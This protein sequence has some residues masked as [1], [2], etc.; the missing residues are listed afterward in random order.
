MNTCSAVAF[1]TVVITGCAVQE[2]RYPG[3]GCPAPAFRLNDIQIDARADRALLSGTYPNCGGRV[4]LLDLKSGAE[5]EFFGHHNTVGTAVANRDFTLVL[6]SGDYWATRPEL[7]LWDVHRPTEPQ[8][9]AG[10]DFA[11]ECAAFSPDGT[12]FAAAGGI[13]GSPFLPGQ[14]VLW[15]LHSRTIK[16]RIPHPCGMVLAIAFSPDGSALASASVDGSVSIWSTRDGQPMRS[17]SQQGVSANSVVFSPDGRMLAAAGGSWDKPGWLE[18]WRLSDYKQVVSAS[19][20]E[21]IYA[22]AWMPDGTRLFA[23]GG[24]NA[25]LQ[26]F[27]LQEGRWESPLLVNNQYGIGMHSISISQY[28]TR[29]LLGMENPTPLRWNWDTEKAVFERGMK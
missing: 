3:G 1:A 26:S 13:A 24:E 9:I 21:A 17:L 10:A 12:M 29:L 14:I 7:F 28:G 20:E 15:N 8:R 5:T 22:L 25:T 16:H 18:V 19:R 2:V 11:A 6:S 4:W 23:A 27:A